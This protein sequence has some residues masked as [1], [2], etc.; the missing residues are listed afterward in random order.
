MTSQ[1]SKAP[2]ESQH[3]RCFT[4]AKKNPRYLQTIAPDIFAQDPSTE[5]FGTGVPIEILRDLHRLRPESPVLSRHQAAAE[6]L[7]K[8]QL[9]VPGTNAQDALFSGTLYFAQV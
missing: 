4:R 2:L 9:P 7:K 8:N 3:V 6:F 5:G 1:T